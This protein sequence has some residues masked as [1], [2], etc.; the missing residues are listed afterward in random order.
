MTWNISGMI[1]QVRLV[2][3]AM[4]A[5]DHLQPDSTMHQIRSLCL[6][7]S[8]SYPR[9]AGTKECGQKIRHTQLLS[10]K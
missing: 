5:P 3:L 6:V 9:S 4:L 1:W 10:T 2:I 7:V 8:D